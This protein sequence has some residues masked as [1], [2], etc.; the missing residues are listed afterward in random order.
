MGHEVIV[1]HISARYPKLFYWFGKHFQHKLYSRLGIPVPVKPPT[2][3]DYEVDGV[4]VHHHCF[5]KIKPH[6]LYSKRIINRMIV[7]IEG[8]C[9]KVGIPDWLIG[10]WDNP[11][12]QILTALKKRLNRPVGLVL[13]DNE[14]DF[15][16]RYGERGTQMLNDLDIIGFRSII[17][18]K[19]FITMYGEP[20]RSFIA[21]S[22]V[23]EAFLL[24][25]SLSP[26]V[27]E[28]PVQN[29]VFVG[30]LI[31]RKYPS[32][33]VSA[34]ST[35][36]HNG[37]CSL[38]FIGDGAERVNIERECKRVSYKGK[39]RF[40][41]RIPREEIIKHL[42]QA[43][44]FVMI[45]S[46]EIF[47]LVYLEAMALGVIPIG[48]RNE[49]ID[50]I[51]RDGINGFLCDAGDVDGLASIICKIKEMSTDD[52][53]SI[54]DEAMKTAKEYSDYGVASNYI[55]SLSCL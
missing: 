20:K 9:K 45:S 36:Y 30:S 2:D 50:G 47:G 43:D 10:H 52:L 5:R 25:G 55:N 54:S 35:V 8:E 44:V 13:H 29:F 7:Y 6:S 4:I 37:D 11:Q 33:I 26:K 40:T 27:I 18:K 12:L 14:F 3:E 48:S 24:A 38:T 46:G 53:Q 21:S 22:G 51:I 19:N 15:E 41:G 32:V 42:K 28:H 39:L 17:G 1:F 23:S 31:A 49:G 16:R 34:L